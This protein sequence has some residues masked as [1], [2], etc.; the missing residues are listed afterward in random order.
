MKEFA[1]VGQLEGHRNSTSAYA[2]SSPAGRAK[3]AVDVLDRLR[4]RSPV[5][6]DITQAAGAGCD[7]Q[8]HHMIEVDEWTIGT[9][10]TTC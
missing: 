10:F 6:L 3:F 4:S 5:V 8:S 9:S 1:P 2:G 7:A